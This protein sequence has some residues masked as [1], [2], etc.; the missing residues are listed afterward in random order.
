MKRIQFLC[1]VFILVFITSC[2]IDYYPSTIN[3]PLLQEKHDFEANIM[4]GLGGNELQIAYS[5]VDNIGVFSTCSYSNRTSSEESEAN[6][7]HKHF[8]LEGALGYYFNPTPRTVL[9]VYG[10]L[11]WGRTQ[12]LYDQSYFYDYDN[13]H[14]Y[15]FFLQPVFGFTGKYMEL[16]ISPRVVAAH[17]IY[18]KPTVTDTGIFVEPVFFTKFGMK[19][20]KLITQF[21][22][23]FPMNQDQLEL[24]HNPFIFSFGINVDLNLLNSDGE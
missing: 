21:G 7:Y 23:C 17:F 12:G 13:A 15:K 5:P 9:S 1:V 6:N 11:G 18:L 10:G 14:Y 24:Q 8:L 22:L 4:T 20:V 16:G 19:S 2:S 3:A